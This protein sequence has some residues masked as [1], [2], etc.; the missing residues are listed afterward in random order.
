MQARLTI[1][2]PSLET[3]FRF[4][5]ADWY[6]AVNVRSRSGPGTV[7]RETGSVTVRVNRPSRDERLVFE[8]S[9]VPGQSTS[10]ARPVIG[11]SSLFLLWSDRF[12]PVDFDDWTV[13]R[14]RIELPETFRALARDPGC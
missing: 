8:L 10:E 9:G 1:A 6:G 12:Y 3:Q 7:T 14:T 2:N 11:D 4:L 13:V 5:L